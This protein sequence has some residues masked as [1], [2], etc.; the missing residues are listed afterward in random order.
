MSH[1]LESMERPFLAC[2][3]LAGILVY[4]GIHVLSRKVIFVDLALAQIAALGSVWGAL[5]GWD[6]QTDPWQIKAFSLVFTLLGAAVFTLTRMRDERV[7]H[8]A[9]I[10]ITYAVALGGTML[11]SAHLA[12][13]AEEVNELLAG[14]ILFVS[15][16]T[17]VLTAVVFAAIGAF[18]WHFR[19]QFFQISL[20]PGGAEARG[21]SLRLWDFLFYASL[22]FAVTSA[23]SIAGV[24]LV[25]S[26]LVIPAVVAML[27]ADS[28]RARLAIGWVVGTLVS[29]IGCSVS[30]FGDLPSGP[31]IVACFGGALVLAGL[32]HYVIVHGAPAHG[33]ALARVTGGAIA[34]AALVAGSFLL[35]KHEGH[36]VVHVLES[37]SKAERVLALQEVAAD[38]ALWSRVQPLVPKLLESRENEVRTD[39]LGLIE[40]KKD[41]SLLPAVHALF[42]DPDDAVRDKALRCV[43]A[44]GAP[45][46][47]PVLAA[48]ATK[49]EDDYIKV[50][51]GE[52]LLELGQLSGVPPILH[53][54][55]SGDAAEARK[56]AWEHLR[57]HLPL[58]AELSPTD[59]AALERW[60]SENE[61]RLVPDPSGMF[62]LGP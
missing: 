9:L 31:T 26:Y 30:Y 13:G 59:F 8:E 15:K 38:P 17:I 62:K 22:G 33:R 16:E 3:L 44:I 50:E 57:A 27:F 40:Q 53:V 28:I 21:V 41:A 37:G 46:S 51:I 10:G 60:W 18:H 52:T 34:V 58:P 29:A 39:L 43:R 1:F 20:D 32:A 35:R 56:D 36:D 49:E 61:K 48:A 24:L 42:S 11:A 55:K 25:F 54:L 6:I 2:L 19:R 23:V 12:H 7:P 5:L 45:E 47:V 4:L 14:S